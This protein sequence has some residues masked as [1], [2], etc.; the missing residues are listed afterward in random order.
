MS[1]EAKTMLE[2]LFPTSFTASGCTSEET[3][4]G[5]EFSMHDQHGVGN[6]SPDVAYADA[7]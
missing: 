3:H 5:D 2:S 6:T 4:K 7:I 1:E